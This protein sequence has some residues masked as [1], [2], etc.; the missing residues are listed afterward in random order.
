MLTVIVA[1][2]AFVLGFCFGAGAVIRQVRTGRLVAGGRVY[3]C[4]DTGPVVR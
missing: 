2:G 1:V 4:M 3:R